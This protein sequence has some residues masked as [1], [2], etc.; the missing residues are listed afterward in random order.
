MLPAVLGRI[1]SPSYFT[2][3]IGPTLLPSILSN[4]QEFLISLSLLGGYW[5]ENLV[6]NMIS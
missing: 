3:L 6:T 1:S 4:D 2:L 5:T